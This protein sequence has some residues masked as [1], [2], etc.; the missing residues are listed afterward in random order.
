[1]IGPLKS[2]FVMSLIIIKFI[3]TRYIKQTV[4]NSSGKVVALTCG[5]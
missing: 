5:V 1:M 3:T 2:V 4:I